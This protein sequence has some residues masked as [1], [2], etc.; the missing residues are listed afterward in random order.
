MEP[1]NAS[2]KAPNDLE[3]EWVT[4][5]KNEERRLRAIRETGGDEALAREIARLK[6]NWNHPAANP[7]AALR[8]KPEE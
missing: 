1:N 5:I 3:P 6:P 8:K 4:R 7:P 2:G